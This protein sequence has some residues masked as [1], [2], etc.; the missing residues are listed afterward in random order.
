[1]QKSIVCLQSNSEHMDTKIK[2]QIIYIHYK[3]Q[4][5]KNSQV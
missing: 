2:S 4:K 1:M 3:G 5:E